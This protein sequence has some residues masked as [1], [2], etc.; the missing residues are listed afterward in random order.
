MCPACSG[1]GASKDRRRGAAAQPAVSPG[2][3]QPLWD[4]VTRQCPSSQRCCSTDLTACS[5]SR[6]P[7]DGV[8][9][10]HC[11]SGPVVTVQGPAW[12]GREWWSSPA[13]KAACPSRPPV[14]LLWLTP[15]AESLQGKQ[16][17][18]LGEGARP[19]PG[20]HPPAQWSELSGL[21]KGP[22]SLDGGGYLRR[23][24]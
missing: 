21:W 24:R 8:G 13:R 11:S 15:L 1:V 6:W 22:S 7:G 3:P 17:H 2:C 9:R 14:G 4:T 10:G 12:V 16:S 23:E 19:P 18:G 20:P 5:Q